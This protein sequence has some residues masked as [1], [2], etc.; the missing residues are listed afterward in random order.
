MNITKICLWLTL[1]LCYVSCSSDKEEATIVGVNNTS[2]YSF[3]LQSSLSA[4]NFKAISKNIDVAANTRA[5]LNSEDSCYTALKPLIT[6]GKVIQEQMIEQAKVIESISDSDIYFIHNI[7]EKDLA[8]LS[9][10]VYNL[11]K[12]NDDSVTRSISPDRLRDCLGFALGVSTIK[13]LS[14]KGI[15]TATTLRRALFAVGK[16]YLGYIGVVLMIADFND[17]IKGYSIKIPDDL[18]KHILHAK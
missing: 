12:I 15:V 14:V 10:I 16:R 11:N 18:T 2:C 8:T 6:D 9:F 3:N 4:S 7:S 5:S 17:C 1:M 13:E